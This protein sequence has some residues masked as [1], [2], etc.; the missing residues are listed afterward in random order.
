MTDDRIPTDGE[1]RG[2]D[3]HAGQSETR[4]VTV[5]RDIDAAHLLVDLAKLVAFADDAANAPE[6]RLFARAKAL[7]T[8]DEAVDRRAPRQRGAE[9]SRERIR[10]S[11]MA[12][13]LLKWQSPV[14]YCSLL[15][16][17]TQRAVR[18]EGEEFKVGGAH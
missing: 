10:A 17:Q 5:R 8:L 13:D 6:A 3:L 7:A 18:R 1:Y 11:T 14:F 12:C 9:L 15:D 16:Y 2:V 4:L